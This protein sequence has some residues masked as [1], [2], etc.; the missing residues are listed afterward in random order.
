M[1]TYAVIMAGG[2]G[3]RF[4]PVSKKDTPKQCLR[5]VSNKSMIQETVERLKPIIDHDKFYIATGYHLYEPIKKDLPDV[6]FILEP[7]A[8]NTAACIGL[9]AVHLLHNDPEAIMLLETS[10]HYYQ[11]EELYRQHLLRAIEYAVNDKICLIGIKPTYSATGYGYIH[12]GNLISDGK[13]R[14]FVVE[15]FVEK[16]EIEVA[17][18]YLESGK[19]LWN[20]GMFISKASIMLEEIEKYMPNLYTGLM[21]IQEVL[22][23]ADTHKLEVVTKEVF[24]SLPANEVTSIDFGVMEKSSNVVVVE[25]IFPWCDVGSWASMEDIHPKDEEGNVVKV[26]RYLPIDSKHNIIFSSSNK[27]IATIGIDNLVVVETV[28]AI[29]VC[30]KQRAEEV[31]KIVEKLKTCNW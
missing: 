23:N 25:G 2:S 27:L 8:C 16:P 9:S 21:K 19:Y 7:M 18:K 10:D 3:T 15:E 6:R 22:K 26:A 1:A 29:L 12:Q 11:N 20:S 17:K 14:I 5:I 4:W 28:D 30:P 13:I 24:E 31:K